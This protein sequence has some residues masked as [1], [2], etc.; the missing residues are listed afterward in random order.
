MLNFYNISCYIEESFALPSVLLKVND[1][2]EEL[3][4]FIV[5]YSRGNLSGASYTSSLKQSENFHWGS[6]KID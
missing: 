3:S 5:V 2:S 1:V 4:S 6:L